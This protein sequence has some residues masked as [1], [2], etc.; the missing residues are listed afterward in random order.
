MNCQD[1]AHWG[2]PDERERGAD[3]RTCKAV[4]HDTNGAHM[5][6][7]VDWDWLREDDPDEFRRLFTFSMAL[8][9]VVDGSGYSARLR[10]R[11][12]FGCVLFAPPPQED[13]DG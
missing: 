13:A 8:A 11:A 6:D 1:C 2:A 10:T 4:P 5:Y 9:V 7:P 12:A 3:V